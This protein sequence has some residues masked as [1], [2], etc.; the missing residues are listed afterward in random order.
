MIVTPELAIAPVIP[1][2]IAPIVQEKLLATLEVKDMLGP[3]PLQVLALAALVTNGTG[4]TITVMV[5]TEPTQV[6]EVDVGVIKY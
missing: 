3:E 5:Y 4:F 2:V 1:P 6:P